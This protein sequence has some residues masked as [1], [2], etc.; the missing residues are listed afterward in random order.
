MPNL[1][2]SLLKF[3]RRLFFIPS[4]E[5][6]LRR[7]IVGRTYGTLVTRF[8]PKHVHYQIP[9]WKDVEVNGIKFRVDVSDLVGWYLYWGFVD[10]SRLKLY[11]L[12]NDGDVVVDVGANLGEVALNAAKR[13]GST[14]QV[15]VFEPFPSNFEKLRTNVGLNR[16][17]NLHLINKGL[18]AESGELGMFVADEANAGMNRMSADGSSESK[19]ATV[20]EV[21]K[22][23]DFILENGIDRIDLIKIDVEGFEMN[24]L[25][26]SEN[27][28]KTFRP[29]L[30]LEVIDDYLRQQG[31]SARDVIQF[32][33]THNYSLTYA[34]S[35]KPVVDNKDFQ[36]T[37]FDVVAL[38]KETRDEI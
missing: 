27:T 37:Q 20:V 33:E 16:F 6:S 11:S 30:F 26:G 5:K 31:S 13:V 36:G 15:F 21:V 17:E 18:G 22:L 28:L 25:R 2:S 23:D 19:N 14:G 29:K 9:S 38:P 1:K 34:D 3:V 12:I 24:V 32:L 35:G 7:L 10:P 4:I 8:P